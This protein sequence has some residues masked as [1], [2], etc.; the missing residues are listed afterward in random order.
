MFLN[1]LKYNL[2]KLSALTSLFVI[3]LFGKTGSALP[4]LIAENI[5]PEILKDLRKNIKILVLVTGTNGKTTTQ[6]LLKSITETA[7]LESISNSTGANLKRGV[8]SAMIKNIGFSN[9][10]FDIGIFEVEEATLP[11]IISQINPEYLIVTNLFRDQLD[12]Y[13]ELD[14]T[15]KFILEAIK[16]TPAMEVILNQDDPKVYEIKEKVSNRI[17]TYGIETE[18]IGHKIYEKDSELNTSADYKAENINI[19]AQLNSTFTIKNNAIQ[20]KTPGIFHIYNAVAAFAIAEKLNIPLDKILIGLKN[21]QSAFGRGEIINSENT[22]YQVLLIKNPAGFTLTLDLL[23]RLKNINIGIFL[24]DNI[25]DGKDV[26]WIWDS[27]VEILNHI[28]PNNIFVSGER[29]EDMLLRIK[30]AMGQLTKI[31]ENEYQI[32]NTKIYLMNDI[33]EIKDYAKK[34]N[35]SKI[36]LLPTYTAML[37]TRKVL[38]GKELN[39]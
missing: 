20:I 26:S 32:E 23:T 36:F 13:G 30:Y 12:A 9:K 14:R 3:K 5:Y 7:G 15:Q 4:G 11:K 35:L 39:E 10:K 24:N 29:K 31:S 25:A 8:I 38:L 18:K 19:D 16:L 28:K 22:K 33:A 37:Q 34:L 2:A 27:N 17:T 21:S 6:T 1:T